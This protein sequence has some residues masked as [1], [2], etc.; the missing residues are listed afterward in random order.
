ME[1]WTQGFPSRAIISIIFVLLYL[2]Q[3]SCSN[4]ST[5]KLVITGEEEIV[6]GNVDAIRITYVYHG[7]QGQNRWDRKRYKVSDLP[8]TVVVHRGSILNYGVRFWVDG[9][10][11]Q[12]WVIAA[13]TE[14]FFPENGVKEMMVNLKY[15]CLDKCL[16]SNL[17]CMDGEC[18]ENISSEFPSTDA[19]S[20]ADAL[21]IS[22]C[23]DEEID[24]VDIPIEEDEICVPEECNGRDDD[25]DDLIDEDFDLMTDI[26]NCGECGNECPPVFHAHP[27]CVLGECDYECDAGWTD[28]NGLPGDGCEEECTPTGLP[29]TECDGVDDDCDGEEDEDYV[30]EECGVGVCTSTYVCIAGTEICDEGDP[31]GDDT[32]CNGLDDD[33]DGVPDDAFVPTMECGIGACYRQGVC[34]AGIETCTEGTPEDM[35]E[36]DNDFIDVNCDGIDGDIARAIFVDKGGLDSHPGTM[37]EPKRSIQAG[38]NTASSDPTKDHVYVSIGDYDEQID[39]RDG[40]SVF[41]VY[42]ATDD[43]SRAAD[44]TVIVNS[45]T[46]VA[47]TADGISSDTVVG[48]IT[49]RS[50]DAPDDGDPSYGIKAVNSTGLVVEN[51]SVTSGRGANGVDGTEG[52]PGEGYTGNPSMRGNDGDSGCEYGCHCPTC[53][54]GSCSM[55]SVGTKGTSPCDQHGGDGGAPGGYTQNGEQGQLGVGDA[56]GG[57]GGPATC[58]GDRGH[59][60][61]DGTSPSFSTLWNGA[62]GNGDGSISGTDWVA[63]DGV[64]G[65][66]GTHAGGAG[67]GGG[68]GGDCSESCTDG[69]CT[70]YG[71]A[72]G[73]G[74]AG[75]CGG[76][77]GTKGTG[78]GGSFAI[79]LIDSSVEVRNCQISTGGG[80]NGGRG[81]SGGAGGQSGPGGSGGA[82]ESTD[83]GGF[84][85]NGGTGGTGA[86]GGAGGGGGGGPSIGIAMYGSST[87]TESGNTYSLGS[88]GNGGNSSGNSGENG[89]TA[90]TF[91]F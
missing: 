6:P 39:L 70:S 12:R 74:G 37:A 80:G 84:G 57:E 83:Q 41:G 9:F 60:G 25:C 69:W 50:S 29:E 13:Y 20:D 18:I 14:A 85:G 32:D 75:G 22:D 38:I 51:C 62:A 82:Q 56:P 4:E 58:S 77:P 1:H 36:P 34:T 45:P 24:A 19:G 63:S 10:K 26:L 81:R 7:N 5:V 17:Y 64:D 49:I 73:G 52:S 42:D 87:I 86:Q 72:G 15:N 46:T 27:I 78:G 67:G 11:E 61:T 21:E 47:V 3:V 59:N 66:R 23:T 35:D 89:I 55:P 88:A 40:V 48:W 31:T 16:S 2:F 91:S 43:W 79:F 53:A 30:G 76:Y 33:C 65:T 90:N 54:C 68:G 71:G 8:Q 28:A 44:H